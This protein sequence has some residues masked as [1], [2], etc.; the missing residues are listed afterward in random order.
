MDKMQHNKYINVYFGCFLFSSLKQ[1]II[2]KYI[3]GQ[4]FKMI[5]PVVSCFKAVRYVNE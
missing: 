4:N 3:I 5:L 1:Y 2:A